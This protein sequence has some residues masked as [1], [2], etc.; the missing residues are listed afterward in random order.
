MGTKAVGSTMGGVNAAARGA[1][2]GEASSGKI[3]RLAPFLTV[4]VSKAL[5]HANVHI[6]SVGQNISKWLILMISER[7]QSG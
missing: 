2:P 4:T 3:P 1:T 5:D 6:T 7:W